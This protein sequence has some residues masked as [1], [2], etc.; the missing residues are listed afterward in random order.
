MRRSR[1][2]TAEE[3]KLWR[4]AMRN[5]TPYHP[6]PP[7]P[8]EPPSA[9]PAPIAVVEPPAAIMRAPMPVSR[10]NG[11]DRQTFK[12]LAKG[13]RTVE[14][15]IDLHGMTL[16]AAHAALRRFVELQAGTG[17]RC[18]LVITGKGGPDRPSKLRQEVPLWLET[19]SPP[20][21]A[22]TSAQ[23]KHGGAGALY[24]LLQRRR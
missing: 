12:Q 18:L 16:Q 15:V 2:V 6:A 13:E 10:P 22:V 19:W 14:A 24:V 21:L 23:P 11:I 20:V 4:S 9:P 7:P 1:T 3:S 8:E 17:K 5:V